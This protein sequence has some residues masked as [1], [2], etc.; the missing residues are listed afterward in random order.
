MPNYKIFCVK[1]FSK[2]LNFC[3]YFIINVSFFKS[4]NDIIAR[5]AN[6]NLFLNSYLDRFQIE[7][8]NKFLKKDYFLKTRLLIEIRVTMLFR[9]INVFF[10]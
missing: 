6:V 1:L 3:S 10:N 4:E 9:L 7:T 2:C 8:E 5:T